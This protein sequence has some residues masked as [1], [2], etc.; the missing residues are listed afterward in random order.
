MHNSH[1]TLPVENLLQRAVPITTKT[2]TISLALS[3]EIQGQACL[4]LLQQDSG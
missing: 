1:Y 4:S 2:A 3:A